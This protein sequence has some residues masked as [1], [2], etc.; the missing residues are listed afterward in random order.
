[1]GKRARFFFG[2]LATLKRHVC[3]N[4]K[5]R[6]TFHAH[7]CFW[8]LLCDTCV[9]LFSIIFFS[10]L[11]LR[12]RA[13]VLFF[14]QMHIRNREFGKAIGSLEEAVKGCPEA[15]EALLLLGKLHEQQA[16]HHRGRREVVKAADQVLRVVKYRTRKE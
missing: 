4:R 10:F 5:K 7:F 3:F 15:G 16:A 14:P 9:C 6:G 1:V 11:L 13:R 12:L 2:F 8:K